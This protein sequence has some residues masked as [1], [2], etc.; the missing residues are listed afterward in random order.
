MREQGWDVDDEVAQR[1]CYGKVGGGPVTGNEDGG[2]H[3]AAQM[4]YALSH[5]GLT[6]P[7]QADA[8]WVGAAGS[9]PSYLDD[10]RGAQNHRTTRNT[11]V[12][13]GTCSRPP[14]G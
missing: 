11:V 4:Q 3:C 7:P 14:G 8:S 1:A 10:D 6:F 12:A 13:A 9:G 5:I 2:K